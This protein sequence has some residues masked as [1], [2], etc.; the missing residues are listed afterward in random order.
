[1]CLVVPVL[2]G[3]SF[4]TISRMLEAF[5]DNSSSTAIIASLL[6]F[7]YIFFWRNS[8]RIILAFFSDYSLTFL[9]KN[10]RVRAVRVVVSDSRVC[11]SDSATL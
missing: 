4:L 7:P 10:L 11:V 9:A 5:S 6:P 8:L 3:W 1:M 2:I